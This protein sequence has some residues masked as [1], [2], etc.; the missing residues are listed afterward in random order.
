[1]AG[2]V[3]AGA[4]RTRVGAFQGALWSLSAAELG[5]SAVKEAVKRA[6]IDGAKVERAFMG[7]VL[8][9]AMGQAPARQ[10]VIKAGLPVSVGA[11]TVNKVCGSGLQAGMVARRD[12]LVGHVAGGLAGGMG[13]MSSAPLPRADGG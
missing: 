13:G 3:I 12:V 1:M 2:V 8:P 9:A 10:A 6:G 11:V 5:A 4:C 7:N